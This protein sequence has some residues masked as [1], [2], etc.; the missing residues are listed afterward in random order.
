M[1]AGPRADE[2][3]PL[4]LGMSPLVSFPIMMGACAFSTSIG[5]IQFIKYG[6]YSR[7]ITL[8]TSTFGVIEVLIAVYFIKTLNLSLLMDY[9]NYF[10]L[11]QYQHV[12]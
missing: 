8:F 4:Q 9:R 12:N 11:H 3:K 2:I 7:K 1:I 6:E 5:S 10:I